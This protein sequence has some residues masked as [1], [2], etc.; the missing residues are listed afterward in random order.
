MYGQQAGMRLPT[1]VQ[2]FYEGALWSS[3]RY[4][5]ATALAG[6][7]ADSLF[8]VRKGGNGQGWPASLTIAE[9]NMEE[10]GRIA[11][12]LAFTTRQ[13]AC[14]VRYA[15][16]WPMVHVDLANVQLN[17]VLT[18]KFLNTFV[19]IAPVNLIGQGGGIFGS[20]ADTGAADGGSGGSRTILNNGA[21]QTWI[22]HELP[23]LLPANTT[24]SMQLQWG[25]NATVVDGGVNNSA[26]V[27]R[28]SLIG[29][30]TSAVP[31]G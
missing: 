2:R 7:A 20:T 1:E 4:A 27:I 30:A 8:G 25:G 6:R 15:D 18:W 3:Y 29:V 9:T 10:A 17:L 14:E 26:M 31:E 22:Y 21:G 11:T 28:V 13:I 16:N 23:V 19:D 24:F 5:D 12:G